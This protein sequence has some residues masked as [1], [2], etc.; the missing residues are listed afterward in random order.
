MAQTHAEVELSGTKSDLYF[1]W[2]LL[3]KLQENEIKY[4]PKR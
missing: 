2:T 4:A 1:F 3:G